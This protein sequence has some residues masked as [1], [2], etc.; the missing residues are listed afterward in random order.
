MVYNNNNSDS[1]YALRDITN[2]HG[3]RKSSIGTHSGEIQIN[4]MSS[5]KA[6][7]KH[8]HIASNPFKNNAKERQHYFQLAMH[9]LQQK[10]YKQAETY[11]QKAAS[12]GC[13]SALYRLGIMY[14]SE[15]LGEEGKLPTHTKK[16]LNALHM[17]ATWVTQAQL[18]T[19]VHFF[20]N[21]GKFEEAMQYYVQGANMGCVYAYKNIGKMY[22]SGHGVPKDNTVAL[23]YF[24]KCGSDRH[25]Q[26]ATRSV[27][28]ETCYGAI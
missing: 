19:L 9:F 17:Q 21:A 22:E 14:M 12:L 7:Q 27:L 6:A 18:Q 11:F 4:D 5:D 28:N 10:E 24:R 23:Q 2:Q 1:Q 8:I 3:G 26:R 20:F 15:D 13:S 16:H 25:I